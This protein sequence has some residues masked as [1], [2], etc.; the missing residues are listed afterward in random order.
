MPP[1]LRSA[2]P[3]SAV[4]VF[5]LALRLVHGAHAAEPLHDRPVAILGHRGALMSAPENTLSAFA[6]CLAAAV[7]IELDVYPTRDGELVVIHDPTVDRTTDGTGRV[8]DLTLEQIRALDAGSWFHSDYADERVPTLQ[9]ALRLVVERERRATVVAI[10]LKPV[11]EV[12][13]AGVIEAV[14]QADLFDRSFVFDLSSSDARR[15]NEREPRMRCAASAT[16]ADAISEALRLDFIDIIWTNPKPRSVIDEIHASGKQVY[17]TLINSASEWLRAQADGVDGICTN[18]PL[19][20][21]A[22]GFAPPAER[23]WDHYLKVDQRVH[24]RF[25]PAR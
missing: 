4:A 8:A 9:E 10:N 19:E 11:T 2:R 7:D 16:T 23:M 21:K 14:R 13:V 5:L 24:Y 22:V 15:F 1:I 6:L 18:Y 3:A 20:M 25:R 12:V 17:F